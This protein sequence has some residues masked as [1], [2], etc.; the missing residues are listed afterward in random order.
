MSALPLPDLAQCAEEPIR[1]PGA[2]Q[3]HGRMLVL[4]AGDGRLLA[5][6]ANWPGRDAIEHALASL[7]I[8]AGDL[9]PEQAPRW[10]GSVQI[11][12]A[13]H[14][15]AAHRQG[16]RLVVEYEPAGPAA[17]MQAPIYAV[18][19]E[20]LPQLQ[21]AQTI[22]QL[23]EVVAR[24][25]KRLTG[26]GRCLVYRFDA[27]GHGEVLAERL[28]A[29]YDAYAGHRFPATDVPAQ[30]RALYLLN[31]IRLIP[32]AN[33]DPVPLLAAAGEDDP[34]GLDLALASLRSVSPV[35]LEYM[36]NM[37]TLAS[38]SVS[39]VSRGRLWGLISCH[40]HEPR[41][42]PFPTRV[43]CEHLGRLLSLQ[44]QALEDNAEVGQRLALHQ[45]VLR[46]VALM[47]ESD[48]TLQRLV[49]PELML[50][51]LA[52]ASGAA[53]VLNDSCW[54]IGE[55]PPPAAVKAL[56]HWIVQRGG[57]SFCTDRLA[58]VWDGGEQML[59]GCAGVLAISISQ[60]HRHVV[61]WFRPE[62]V[63]TIRWAG[64][65]RKTAPAQGRIHPRRSFES[66]QEF[67]RGRSAPWLAAEEGAV[68]ELRQA[69]LSLVLRR[70][71][72]MAGYAEE[73]GR[74]NKELEAFSYT[75]SHDLRAPMRHIAG[76]VDLVLEDNR[77]RLDERSR[78]YLAHVKDAASYA[79]QLVDALLDFS[80][81]GRAGLK[82]SWVDTAVLVE[83]LV[84]ETNQQERGR[85]IEWDLQQ[86]LPRVWADPLLLQVALRNLLSN[87]AKYSRGR[88]PA[89]IRVAAV[90]LP[91]G[92]GLEISDNGVGFPMKYVG[93]LF[94]V[95]QR[96]HRTEDFDGTGIGL[97]N[98]KRIVERHGGS[99]WARGEPDQGATFGF[100]LP[101]PTPPRN[102]AG[103]G[104][105]KE[106]PA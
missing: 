3:P 104:T 74:V 41:H 93:K 49:A 38:M 5:H 82:P 43:A 97:A 34:A 79:G 27:D 73:L 75:V 50:H 46:M 37:G 22:V 65:P 66:W 53:V 31:Q 12:G 98:V 56:A 25:M 42:L 6:S 63:K 10:V 69:L 40:N 33:Y 17:S 92:T 105:R 30:A 16:D 91:A 77:E 36:R 15:A 47:A 2:I 88:D 67:V 106:E 90:T 55:T 23:C 19:N 20:H 87:A 18:A 4:H 21:A 64:D 14:D 9:R 85:R 32:N 45:R 51:E 28:D 96:L 89:R 61:L 59:P 24:E 94:G 8:A 83:D 80:R 101:P 39:I 13:N 100:V 57:T 71:E 81:L 102:D 62:L 70:A 68:G 48:S 78:R 7:P 35:H 99:V 76:Y 11:D 58:E 44:V 29:G 103:D 84:S 52:A 95:F 26:F 72:E 54:T 60:V 86:A 1:T